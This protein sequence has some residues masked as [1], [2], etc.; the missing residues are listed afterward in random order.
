M[1]TVSW[2]I[3]TLCVMLPLITLSGWLFSKYLDWQTSRDVDRY[4]K[5]RRKMSKTTNDQYAAMMQQMQQ[6]MNRYLDRHQ[7]LMTEAQQRRYSIAMELHA[8]EFDRQ[9]LGNWTSPPPPPVDSAWDIL[10]KSLLTLGRRPLPRLDPLAGAAEPLLCSVS[11]AGVHAY[12]D[13]I[14]G[15]ALRL[16]K[17]VRVKFPVKDVIFPPITIE[18]GDWSKDFNIESLYSFSV[19]ESTPAE[20]VLIQA[21]VIP[22]VTLEF[23]AGRPLLYSSEL[24]D[25]FYRLNI[26]RI[27]TR[28]FGIGQRRVSFAN[29]QNDKTQAQGGTG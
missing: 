19:V 17:D 8:R 21:A 23:R 18:I 29:P 28:Q 4:F 13:V 2:I 22:F 6:Q 14:K 20:N 1:E 11:I 15:G 10:L 5:D 27:R 3:G 12:A 9:L 7:M 25:V 24:T 26:D 16:Q